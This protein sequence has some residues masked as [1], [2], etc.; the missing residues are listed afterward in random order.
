MESGRLFED[1]RF[2][3]DDRADRALVRDLGRV[4]KALINAGLYPGYAHALIG[5]SIFIRYLEDRRVLEEDYFRSVARG[6]RENWP[7]VLDEARHAHVDFGVGHP[8]LYPYVLTNKGFTYALFRKLANDFN[9]D[10]FPV[11]SEE[12]KAVTPAHLNV[13]HQFLLGGKGENLFFFAYRFDIIPIELISS[14]YEKFY[15]LQK[16]KRRDEGSYYTPSALVD[17]VLAETLTDDLLAKTPRVIDPACGSGIFLV[18]AFRRI[19]RYR[20]GK[21]RRALT[22]DELRAILRDQ[23]AGMDI[24]SEAI[25]VAAFSLYLAMLHYLE[26]PN[27][28]KNKRLPSLTFSTRS[29]TSKDHHFDIL[30]ASDAFSVK[31]TVSNKKVRKRFLSKCADAVVGNPPWAL[32]KPMCQRN[33]NLT[34]DLHGVPS[35][36]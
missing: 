6:D 23:I 16:K 28:Q 20:V 25:R 27:I 10:M 24:S 34:A 31:Q 35:V 17:F 18:E 15:S 12:E 11:D 19:V 8:I 26:P 5:R 7:A 13:L 14:I 33:C 4:R 9:G 29:H 2:G 3:F 32:P 22:P 1:D 36:D 30:I 21:A